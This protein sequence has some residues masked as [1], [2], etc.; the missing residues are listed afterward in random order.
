M[1]NKH[2]FIFNKKKFKNIE[3]HRANCENIQGYSSK[4]IKLNNMYEPWY[5]HGHY[6]KNTQ[7]IIANYDTMQLP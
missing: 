1:D 4:A 3:E 2:C 6:I 5:H 7:Q